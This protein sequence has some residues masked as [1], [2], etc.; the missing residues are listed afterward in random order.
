MRQ[1][2]KNYL[3]I[4]CVAMISLCSVTSLQAQLSSNA[5]ALPAAPAA[6]INLKLQASASSQSATAPAAANGAIELTREQAEKIALKNN[7]RISVEQLLALA[8]HQVTRQARASLMPDLSG[9]VTGVDAVQGSRIAA[10]SLTS[11]RLVQHAALGAEISQIITDFG[12]TQHLIASAHFAERAQQANAEATRE[13]IMLA[14]DYAFYGVLEAQATLRIADQTVKT[15]QTVTDQVAALTKSKLKSDLDLSFANVNLSEAKLLQLDSKAQ[16]DAAM[17]SLTAVLGS[18]SRAQY[19]LIEPDTQLPLP[20]PDAEAEVAIAMQQRPDL[21]ALHLTQQSAMKFAQAQREQLFPT[22]DALGV[23]GK[24]PVGSS[25]YY[26]PNWYGAIGA[27]IN[28]PIFNGFRYAAEANEAKLRAQAAGE[29]S[30][31]LEESIT[32]DVR[33]AWLQAN[34]SFQKVTVTEE[35]LKEAN[36]GLDLASTRYQLGLSS[37]VELSQA[38]LQQTQAAISEANA[39]Y[40]YQFSLETL[41]FQTGSHP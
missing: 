31:E 26:T 11:S 24:T 19:V 39:R 12:R 3:R 32:R 2:T 33:T 6:A 13:Q 30:R 37:I 40:Q 29:N 21:Q 10:A 22:I 20:P 34:S 1:Y 4:Y 14:T 35:L 41:L 16:M 8:Q 17:A 25:T 38:Q 36:L 27:N 15:R 18:D 23:V 28:I 7:P 9:D 5:A